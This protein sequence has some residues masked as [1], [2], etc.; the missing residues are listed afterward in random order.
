MR[1]LILPESAEPVYR[2]IF[3]QIA[4][5]ILS[6]EL[7]G[8]TALPPIRTVSRELGTSVITVRSAWEALEAEGLIE[9]RH[10][11]GCYVV[12]LTED[13][14]ERRRESALA[15]PLET[16]IDTARSLGLS[17]EELCERLRQKWRTGPEN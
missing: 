17:A 12:S 6:G 7:A 10:G 8:G 5:Q 9:T 14:K 15:A 3:G 11:S 2:Q 16:L 13:E 1:L 4:A